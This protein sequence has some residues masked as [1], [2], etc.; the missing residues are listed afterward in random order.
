MA[1]PLS[2]TTVPTAQTQAPAVPPETALSPRLLFAVMLIA[3]VLASC[4][5]AGHHIAA[6]GVAASIAVHSSRDVPLARR[7]ASAASRR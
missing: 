1:P 3:A 7:L 5:T 6:M 2:A 4:F